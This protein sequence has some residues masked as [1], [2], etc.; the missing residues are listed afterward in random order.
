MKLMLC[1]MANVDVPWPSLSGDLGIGDHMLWKFKR[2]TVDL[3]E[4]II[5]SQKRQSRRTLKDIYSPALACLDL[6]YW[7]MMD[8]DDGVIAPMELRRNQL[9]KKYMHMLRHTFIKALFAADAKKLQDGS[10]DLDVARPWSIRTWNKFSHSEFGRSNYISR[11]QSTGKTPY[12]QN[13]SAERR[14]LNS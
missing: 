2:K 14:Y 11:C 7:K 5:V 6:A 1:T 12:A 4:L 10:W 13:L 3:V 9:H 8:M